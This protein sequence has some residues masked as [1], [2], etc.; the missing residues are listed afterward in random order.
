MTI[1]PIDR[2]QP[3]YQKP[4]ETAAKPLPEEGPAKPTAQ[5]SYSPSPRQTEETGTA[6]RPNA[7]LVDRLK[8]EQQEIQARF[9]STVRDML[10]KQ[11]KGIAEGDGI[12]KL[13]AS[14]D[15][16]VDA[17][18]KADAQSA[19]AEDGYWGVK[20]TSRRIVDFAKALV[21][22][23]P[24]RAEEMR[25]AFLKGFQAAEK[26]W[27]GALPDITRQTHSAVMDLFD[28]WKNEGSQAAE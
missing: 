20:Q 5:D 8:A 1:N 16:Q 22:G 25:E 6:Y 18:T 17:Q 13:L 26:A 2:R 3:S 23:N 11:G 21:G 14:G 19:V 10:T 7:K 24:G 4:M 15:Y 28:Q 27:G 12:W 9:V